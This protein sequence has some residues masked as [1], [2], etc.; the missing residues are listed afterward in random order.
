M[1]LNPVTAIGNT[2]LKGIGNF[3]MSPAQIL[4]RE[5]TRLE[6][7]DLEAKRA[8]EMQMKQ[9]ELNA[10]DAGSGKWYQAGWRPLYGWISGLGFGYQVL[11][12]PLVHDLFGKW[13]SVHPLPDAQMNL[14]LTIGG[15]LICVRAGEKI[16]SVVSRA[17]VK[18]GVAKA[19][20][21]QAGV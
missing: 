21:S 6:Y 18:R 13:I 14:L 7:G 8:H 4:E 3:K 5:K 17:A 2:I 9:L 10:V 15:G 19:G 11:V 12:Q 20:Q 16:N 1:N